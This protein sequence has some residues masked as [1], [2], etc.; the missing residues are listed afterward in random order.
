MHRWSFLALFL[1]LAPTSTFGDSTTTTLPRSSRTRS[2]TRY[3]PWN[4]SKNIDKEGFLFGVWERCPGEW[5]PEA[6]LQTRYGTERPVQIR[7]VPGDGNCLFHSISLCLRYAENGTHWSLPEDMEELYEHSRC[8]REQAVQCLSH[9]RR[10][11]YLQGSERLWAHDLV[12]AAAQQYALSPEDYCEAMEQESVWGGGPEIVA[13]SNVLRRPI[14]VYEL[15]SCHGDRFVLRRMACFGSPRYDRK[16]ALHVLS[17]DSR[18]PDVTPGNQ[19]AAGNHFLSVFP[20]ERK[21]L[22]G[23]G[24]R[25]WGVPKKRDDS[26]TA[27]QP[28]LSWWQRLWKS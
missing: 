17:A 1:L 20:I 12:E 10:R 3:P 16:Q 8:L 23:G 9:P 21:R 19:L 26:V 27:F 11:L 15:I 7:Q 5:E 22:R 24:V 6:A 25:L 14:H 18:F 2:S 4:P 13:L 28:P